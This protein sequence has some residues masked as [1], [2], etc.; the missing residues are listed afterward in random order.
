MLPQ[1]PMNAGSALPAPQVTSLNAAQPIS[2][3]LLQAAPLAAV[4]EEE[5]RLAEQTQASTVIQALAAHVRTMW[6]AARFA[7][8]RTIQER[9]LSSERARRGEYDPEKLTQIQAEG[10]AAVY[11]MLTSVKCRAASSWIRDVMLA[12]GSEKPWT[13]KPTPVPDLKPE[14]AQ[15]IIDRVTAPLQQAIAMGQIPP[16]EE[17]K[18]A[19][20]VLREQALNEERHMARKT[21]ERMEAKMEDQLVEGG[22][23]FALGQ[24]I[25]DITTFPAAFLKGPVVRNRPKTKWVNKGGQWTIDVQRDVGLFW[26]RVSPFDIYP[27][28]QAST[29]EDGYLIERHRLSRGDLIDMIDVPGYDNEAIKL[30]LEEYGRNGLREWLWE[31]VQQ[32]SAEGKAPVYGMENKDNIIDALQFWGSVQG[33]ILREWGMDTKMVPDELRDYNCEIWLIGNYIIKATLNEDPFGRK[34]YFKASYE[35]IPGAF[36]G[37]SPADLVRDAQQIV[38]AAARSLVNNMGIASGPQVEV[39]VDRLPQGEDITKMYPWKIW[40]VTSDP[41]GASGAQRAV[42]FFQPSSNVNE[43]SGIIKMFMDLADEWSGIPKYL[44]GDAPGGAGRTASGLSMLMGNAGKSLKQVIANM[45]GNVIQPILERLYYW[46][47]R[48]GTDE[49]LKGDVCI[50]A[51]GANALVAKEAAQVRRNEFL[52]TTANPIDMQIIGLEGRAEVLRETTKS[53]DLDVDKIVPP[54]DILM[55]TIMKRMQ[56]GMLPPPGGAPAGQ[57]PTA[58]SPT[59]AAPGMPSQSGQTLMDGAP[60]TDQFSPPAQST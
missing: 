23:R 21:A 29:I 24:F 49:D 18:Y 42:N 16:D 14:L 13:I 40:Q 10:G 52:A 57:A 5:R 33:K 7:K 2:V 32:A 25:D 50:V 3:G 4:L 19:L 1:Y 54:E 36:W 38:N 46:N 9:L 30:V 27:S 60:V 22:F 53:L 37:N 12:A 39:N 6:S 15:I 59:P 28:P 34:P 35:E 31:D 44:T 56:A 26:E 51:R 43:L 20:S 8:Q 58:G 17:I 47:M 45:D 11:C 55:Q 48:Y 41:M